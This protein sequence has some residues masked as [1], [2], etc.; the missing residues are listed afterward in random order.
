MRPINHTQNIFRSQRNLLLHEL[1]QRKHKLLRRDF[2]VV[3][4]TPNRLCRR[5]RRLLACRLSKKLVLISYR[6][7]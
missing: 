2:L 6:E 7:S 4:K 1:L 3:E 5:K